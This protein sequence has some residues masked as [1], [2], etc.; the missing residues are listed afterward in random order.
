MRGVG[1]ISPREQQVLELLAEHR[2]YEYIGAKLHI[3]R[4]TVY[5]HVYSIMLKTDIHKKELLIKYAID[6][7][8]RKRRKIAV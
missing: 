7:G 2:T 1:P 5:E 6:H 3:S 4:I 8:F